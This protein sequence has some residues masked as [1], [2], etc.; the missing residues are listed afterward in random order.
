MLSSASNQQD[1]GG[2]HPSHRGS[3]TGGAPHVLAILPGF[4]P[5]TW[6]CVIRPF[7]GLQAQGKVRFRLALELY[8]NLKS[9]GWADLVVF[10]RNAEPRYGYIL[11]KV[12]E[13][14]I[15]FIYDLDDNL[16][17]IPPDLEDGRYYGVPQRK[18]QLE[19]YLRRANLLR[20]YSAK[21]LEGMSVYNPA[22][23]QMDETVDWDLIASAARPSPERRVKIVYA[24]SRRDDYLFSI[25]TESLRRVLDDFSEQVEIHFWGY[26]PPG[27]QSLPHVCYKKY[28][29]NYNQ[30]MRQ[31]SSAGFDIGL[32]PLLDDDFHRAKTNNKFRE[33]GACE[34]AGIYSN[35]PVY[36]GC[37]EDG[38]TGLLVENTPQAWYAAMAR[39]IQDAALRRRLG[40]AA[41]VRVRERYS[42][43]KFEEQWHRQ[44]QEVLVEWDAAR[45]AAG[46]A[47]SA[48][49][50]EAGVGMLGPASSA[51]TGGQIW[52]QKLAHRWR[53]L[54]ED[55]LL[56]LFIDLQFHLRNL[57]WTFKIN[58]LKRM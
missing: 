33:Y 23:Q 29:P 47:S 13:R 9:L 22:I 45:G 12:L 43:E 42:Q 1:M 17:E 25:F 52:L 16:F 36:A 15:P 26:Q 7:M 57:W 21:L 18:K 41:C 51:P 34:I 19:R 2:R 55:G 10:C 35:V 40:Q 5:S 56:K 58:T 27:F 8:P 28:N 31:F 39:L 24:T 20:V 4:M 46:S 3:I 53:S 30:F 44:I 48:P 11:N 14:G 54:R 49:T 37:V 32:A 6:I 50:D 38:V